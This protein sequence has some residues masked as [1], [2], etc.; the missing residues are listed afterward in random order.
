MFIDNLNLI[1]HFIDNHNNNIAF[2]DNRNIILHFIDNHNN[3]I[4]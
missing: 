2:Y 1:L 4:A 3:N